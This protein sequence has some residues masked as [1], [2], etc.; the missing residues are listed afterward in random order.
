MNI[1]QQPPELAIEETSTYVGD[2][3]SLD[4]GQDTDI[5]PD[6]P[7]WKNES[8]DYGRGHSLQTSFGRYRVVE[9]NGWKLILKTSQGLTEIASVMDSISS[10]EA[11]AALCREDLQR[12]VDQAL[13]ALQVLNDLSQ[14]PS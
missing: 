10:Q 2:I 6:M 12:R 11:L 1:V 9:G 8:K 14:L 3:V 5:V 7:G 13:Q 4:L